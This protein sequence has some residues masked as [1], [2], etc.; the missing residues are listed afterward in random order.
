MSTEAGVRAQLI[1][2]DGLRGRDIDRTAEHVR[3]RT[4]RTRA[5]AQPHAAI[6]RW[7][8]SGLFYELRAAG[9]K[10][11]T[12]SP[13]TLL[14]V[15]AADLAFRLRWEIRP[16]I[17]AGHAII[18]APYVETAFAF[19][20][21]AGISRRWMAELL[22]FAPEADVR[23]DAGRGKHRK[24]PK[25][26]AMDGFLEFAATASRSLRRRTPVKR[27]TDR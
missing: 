12:L 16:A 9:K 5:K 4:R 22:R 7:D 15:Y 21:T 24:L 1:A 3:R 20:K 25:P 13:R 23:V 27:S 19:G 6:S 11:L 17:E 26:R 14:L 10:S 8:A 2:V 18:A